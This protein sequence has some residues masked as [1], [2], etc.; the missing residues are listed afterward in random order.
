MANLIPDTSAMAEE[1]IKGKI[2][3]YTDNLPEEEANAVISDMTSSAKSSM[4]NKLNEINS[5]YG[6]VETSLNG[7]SGI[8]LDLSQTVASAAP[9]MPPPAGVTVAV[10]QI[11]AGVKGWKAQA[12]DANAKVATMKNSLQLLAVGVPALE[13]ILQSLEIIS[14]TVESI[15]ESLDAIPIE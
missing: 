4:E 15:K 10:S 9:I 13:P 6:Q 2:K 5:I 3:G 1:I 14:G 11:S 7:L 12:E 8:P